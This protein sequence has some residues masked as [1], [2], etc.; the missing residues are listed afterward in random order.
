M[1]SSVDVA[2]GFGQMVGF[3]LGVVFWVVIIAVVVNKLAHKVKK[4]KIGIRWI[5]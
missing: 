2:W 4:Q 5:R 1:S 3:I